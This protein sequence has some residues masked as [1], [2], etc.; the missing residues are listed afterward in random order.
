MKCQRCV[1]VCDFGGVDSQGIT[2]RTLE[3]R[4][5]GSKGVR[6]VNFQRIT[7]AKGISTNKDPEAE[8][9]LADWRHTTV[10]CVIGTE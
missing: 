6:Q 3:K 8:M 5:E 10:S 1:Y 9:F 2:R 4:C 7:Q